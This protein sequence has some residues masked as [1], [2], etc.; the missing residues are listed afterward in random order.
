MGRG[1]SSSQSCAPLLGF[2]N[3][4]V[5]GT[6]TSVVTVRMKKGK[7]CPYAVLENAARIDM[8]LR[9]CSS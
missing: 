7:N 2:R 8:P 1:A 6:V 9:T 3:E 4:I 5:V